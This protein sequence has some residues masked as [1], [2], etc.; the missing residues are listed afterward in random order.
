MMNNLN[1]LN[2][3]SALFVTSLSTIKTAFIQNVALNGSSKFLQTF[4]QN[5]VSKKHFGLFIP[6]AINRVEFFL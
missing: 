3:F 5:E 4:F 2:R 1:S 6:I